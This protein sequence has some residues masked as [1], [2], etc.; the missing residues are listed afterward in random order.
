MRDTVIKLWIEIS[1][2]IGIGFLSGFITAGFVGI[3]LLESVGTTIQT[4]VAFLSYAPAGGIIGATL[5]G[6]VILFVMGHAALAMNKG[7]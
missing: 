4:I 7:D 5:A 1:K 2:V 6:C 3:Q